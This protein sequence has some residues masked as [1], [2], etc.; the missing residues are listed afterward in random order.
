MI[1]PEN[2]WTLQLKYESCCGASRAV[3]LSPVTSQVPRRPCSMAEFCL[4]SS[5]H[6]L[7]CQEGSLAP[8]TKVPDNMSLSGS[9]ALCYC[10]T[11]RDW[12]GL[13]SSPVGKAPALGGKC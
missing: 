9:L 10:R 12:P 1:F 3:L 11:P 2:E 5:L 6:I 8:S 7:A 4:L 13:A